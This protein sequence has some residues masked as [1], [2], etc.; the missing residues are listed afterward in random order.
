MSSFCCCIRYGQ[1]IDRS[2]IFAGG[3]QKSIV[4]GAWALVVLGQILSVIAASTAGVVSL[5]TSSYEDPSGVPVGSTTTFTVETNSMAGLAMVGNILYCIGLIVYVATAIRSR[6]VIRANY[7]IPGGTGTDC[8]AWLFC[9]SCALCQEAG[10]I[11]SLLATYL[12]SDKKWFIIF[13][14]ILPVL[15]I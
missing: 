11:L 3:H 1:N 14:I 10:N 13:L 8:L 9:S 5:D 12:C 2:G 15:I 6:G 7:G 4:Y